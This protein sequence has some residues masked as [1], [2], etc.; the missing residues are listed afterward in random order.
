MAEMPGGTTVS[1]V[2][3]LRAC[4][5]A[6][7]TTWREFALDSVYG[8]MP[9][10]TLRDVYTQGRVPPKWRRH[11][12]LVERVRPHRVAVVTGN[13]DSAVSTLFGER[14]IAQ[15][16]REEFIRRVARMETEMEY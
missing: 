4:K 15:E 14:G 3:R 5:D 8:E 10:S 1:F 11:Y 9:P 7:P 16:L 12:G 2:R 13:V 6:K